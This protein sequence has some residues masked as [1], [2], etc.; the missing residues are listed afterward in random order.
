MYTDE[1]GNEFSVKEI[2]KKFTGKPT[3]TVD[4]EKILAKNED[5]WGDEKIVD[6]LA[7]MEKDEL[8]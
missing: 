8:V 3:V 2:Q 6:I 4:P 1:K 5:A 7:E